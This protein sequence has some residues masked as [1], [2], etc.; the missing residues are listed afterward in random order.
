MLQNSWRPQQRALLLRKAGMSSA[1]T[2]IS[3]LYRYARVGCRLDADAH[4]CITARLY[5][6][7]LS[8]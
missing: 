8:R 1:S 7:L 3:R 2:D 5:R 4:C 6:S